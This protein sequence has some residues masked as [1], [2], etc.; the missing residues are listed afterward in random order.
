MCM[1]LPSKG[2]G[3]NCFGR[4]SQDFDQIARGSVEVFGRVQRITV[5]VVLGQ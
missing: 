4:A 2:L 5:S 1:R 3:G